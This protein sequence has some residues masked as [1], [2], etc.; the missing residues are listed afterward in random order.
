[1]SASGNNFIVID[2]HENIVQRPK[3]FAAKVCKSNAVDGVLFIE[4]PKQSSEEFYMRIINAD[5]SEAEACGNGYRCVGLYAKEHLNIQNPNF[6]RVG[7]LGGPVEI[8]VNSPEAIKVKMIE[9]TDYRN[10][11]DINLEP[12]SL[13]GG[14]IN[15]GVPHVVIFQESLGQ[16]PVVEWGR[17]IRNYKEFQPN[18]A[19]VNFVEVTGNSS[20]SIRT[21]ERGV[22]NETGACGTGAVASAIIASLNGHVKPPVAVT[23]TSGESLKVYF[24][25]SN[26]W[27]KDVYLEGPA[28]F[29]SERGNLSN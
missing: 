7:T 12:I 16:I 2:N 14:F 10:N 24:K 4:N 26:N 19:N 18:G 28:K 6:I 22:E 13:K 21:Y 25:Q 20:L 15:T 23:P 8:A 11:I 1:M 5:G 27:I 3:D 29:I 17:K 9:P